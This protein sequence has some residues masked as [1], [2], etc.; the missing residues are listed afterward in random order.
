LKLLWITILRQEKAGINIKY[1][2]P[3]YV[4]QD[5]WREVDYYVNESAGLL[6]DAT[7]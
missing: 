3:E 5:K 2:T 7:N 6:N 4:L 1:D